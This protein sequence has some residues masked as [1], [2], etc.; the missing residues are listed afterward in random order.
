MKGGEGTVT[1]V[2]AQFDEKVRRNGIEAAAREFGVSEEIK[3]TQAIRKYARENN[4]QLDEVLEGAGPVKDLKEAGVPLHEVREHV[5]PVYK[6]TRDRP[7][8]TVA[9][10]CQE[11][12]DLEE[13]YHMPFSEIK[14]RHEV[15]GKEVSN[16][17]RSRE[18]LGKEVEGLDKEKGRL[19]R[20]NRT[21]EDELKTFLEDKN[22]LLSIGMDT[23]DHAAAT[24]LLKSLEGLKYKPAAA[25]AKLVSIN[26]LE[27]SI[28]ALKGEQ[29]R[30]SQSIE[31]SKTTLSE[32]EGEISE[33]RQWL[34]EVRRLGKA[35]VD[36]SG[37]AEVRKTVVAISARKSMTSK[38]AMELFLRDIVKNYDALLGLDT[39]IRALTTREA[40]V[41]QRI[42]GAEG[43][44]GVL[45]NQYR[46]RKKEWDAFV[47]L[48]KREISGDTLVRWNT[49]VA[50]AG[51]DPELV[52]KELYRYRD[53]T[54]T[55]SKLEKDLDE[56]KKQ[57][58]V[59]KSEIRGLETNKGE[60]VASIKTITDEAIDRLE[61][62][63]K[64]VD[65]SVKEATKS[66]AD[67]ARNL[68]ET[69]TKAY[70]TGEKIGKLGT[71]RP[72]IEF[73]DTGAGTTEEV[74]AIGSR[75]AD[76]L[77]RWATANGSTSIAITV[78]SLRDDI[79]RELLKPPT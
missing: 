15:L 13:K 62:H 4:L 49:V 14:Q 44:L 48:A 42:K 36:L 68:D 40:D 11:I 37:I 10:Q 5:V 3:E 9:A 45:D 50:E 27:G 78:R 61:S 22:F 60:L 67:L 23:R 55:Y 71:L 57:R 25:V 33:K 77:E 70:Q 41:N 46:S 43:R 17:E 69:S 56:L 74:L 2:S 28:A 64:K 20:L 16:M 79:R 47:S 73:L 8:E 26:D 51:L 34:L 31:T 32:I 29:A 6:L 12:R 1:R 19:L 76:R 75:F 53:L 39:N 58:G 59:L 66:F 18:K 24:K 35:G 72:G 38:R 54:Q 30:L 63:S 52:A 7:P 21:T 65:T